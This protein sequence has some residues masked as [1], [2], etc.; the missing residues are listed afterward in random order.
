[1]GLVYLKRDQQRVKLTFQSA[2]AKPLH[3]SSNH[4]IVFNEMDSFPMYAEQYDAAA[5]TCPLSKPGEKILAF[6]SPYNA[7]SEFHKQRVLPHADLKL[8][9]AT[10]EMNPT[11]PN[12]YYRAQKEMGVRFEME[13]GADT[14]C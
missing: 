3:G 1:V 13:F 2:H 4:L 11:I 14:G 5:P 12:E 10:W 7:S 9:I 8:R 6:S